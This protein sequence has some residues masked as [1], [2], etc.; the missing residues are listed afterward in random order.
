MSYEGDHYECI[1]MFINCSVVS[2]I[3][4][5]CQWRKIYNFRKGLVNSKSYFTNIGLLIV[6]L[7]FEYGFINF[8]LIFF[9]IFDTKCPYARVL[10][11]ETVALEI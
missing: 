3:G 6:I 9:G 11:L 7:I 1:P 2:T 5:Y 8:Q 4:L 10:G